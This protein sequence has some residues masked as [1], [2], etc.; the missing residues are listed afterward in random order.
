VFS[1]SPFGCPTVGAQRVRSLHSVTK[2]RSV[3]DQFSWNLE[4]TTRVGTSGLPHQILNL[5][6][7]KERQRIAESFNPGSRGRN[8]LPKPHQGRHSS[9]HVTPWGKFARHSHGLCLGM[10]LACAAAIRRRRAIRAHCRARRDDH[11]AVALTLPENGSPPE[12]ILYP[13]A[14]I[15][16][17]HP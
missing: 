3:Q 6:P 4:L 15:F 13:A 11:R 1:P 9:S 5:S 17:L 8:R 7:S 10:R 2:T 14:R 16:D 12:F